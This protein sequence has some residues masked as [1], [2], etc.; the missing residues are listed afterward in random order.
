LNSVY[1][2]NSNPFAYGEAYRNGQAIAG[3]DLAGTLMEEESVGSATR[4][5][6]KFVS[7]PSI[8]E[9]MRG[10]NQ[11]T[12]E[13]STDAPSDSTVEYVV[14]YPPYTHSLQSS[15]LVSSHSITV[16]NLQPHTLYHY[17]VRSSAQGLRSVVSRD[18]VICTKPAS[19]NLLTNPGFEEGAG[20]SP[21]ALG[22][23]WVYLPGTDVQ[24]SSGN[25]FFSLPPYSGNWFVQYSVNG[26]SSSNYLYQIVSNVVV[27]REYTFSAWVMTAMRE[28]DNWKY[29][30][31]HDQGRLIHIRIGLDPL[32]GSNPLAPSVQW[33]PR[34]YSHRHYTPL[35]KSVV[36]QSTNLTV[37]V[38]MQGEGGQWHLYAIDACALT[39]EPIPIRFVSN[40]VSNGMFETKFT[41]RANRTNALESS[42]NGTTW[43]GNGIFYNRTGTSLYREFSI[44]NRAQKFFRARSLP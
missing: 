36:A 31:W 21:R 43:F 26:G 14:E 10:S 12:I 29:D 5:T 2:N 25:H 28:N 39:H 34:M 38:R 35:A 8:S 6:V 23:P 41:S 40:I 17:R 27:G 20:S 15:D 7:D 24:V 30:V 37:F 9:P 11:V 19:T 42:F 3:T 1:A 16:S 13:W 44:T 22:P 32:G 4:N 18:F 33:T